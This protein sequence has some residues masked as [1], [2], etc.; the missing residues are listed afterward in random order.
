MMTGTVSTYVLAVFLEPITAMLNTI[1]LAKKF[2]WVFTVTSYLSETL[3]GNFWLTQYLLDTLNSCKPE[4]LG[5][6]PAP[7]LPWIDAWPWR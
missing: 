4:G 7:A 1:G 6:G 3:E 5:V 2:V